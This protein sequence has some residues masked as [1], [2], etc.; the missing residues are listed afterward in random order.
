MFG[1]MKRKIYVLFALALGPPAYAQVITDVP[2]DA[3]QPPLTRKEARRTGDDWT[4]APDNDTREQRGIE[5]DEFGRPKGVKP[6]TPPPSVR[7][8]MVGGYGSATSDSGST[9][10]MPK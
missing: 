5:Y 2:A 4:R 8:D 7:G 1:R 3:D 10:S 9:Q 6:G